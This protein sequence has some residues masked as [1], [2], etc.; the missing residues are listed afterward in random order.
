MA[1]LPDIETLCMNCMSVKSGA[2]LPCPHCGFPAGECAALSGELPPRTILFGRYLLGRMTGR[3]SAGVLYAAYDLKR[4]RRVTIREYFPKVYAKREQIRPG[5]SRVAPISGEAASPFQSGLEQSEIKARQLMRL[6]ALS[7]LF[8][9]QK[10]FS[11]NGTAYAVLDYVQGVTLRKRMESGAAAAPD[12]AEL[13]RPIVSSLARLHGAGLSHGEVSLGQVLF[14]PEGTLM[15]LPPWGAFERKGGPEYPGNARAAARDARAICAALYALLAGKEPPPPSGC[16]KAKDI[17]SL[18]GLGVSVSRQRERA[19]YKG[20][21]GGYRDA[22]ELHWALYGAAPAE[23]GAV[24]GRDN[25]AT[26]SLEKAVR[27]ISNTGGGKKTRPSPPARNGSPFPAAY[28]AFAVLQLTVGIFSAARGGG[29]APYA[30]FACALMNGLSLIKGFGASPLIRALH[31]AAAAYA[32]VF[33]GYSL[34]APGPAGWPPVV[35][36]ALP[37]LNAACILLE[38]IRIRGARKKPKQ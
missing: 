2:A 11:E 13:I 7:G 1:G 27:T 30:L 29:A 22:R 24:R 16:E 38:S 34:F 35:S 25:N 14:T 19:I 6:G 20:L 18:T 15:L 28:A 12:A 33:A 4:C 23:A 21:C 36:A 26:V 10:C 5:V 17:P 32:A 9:P 37:L 31:L 3:W 8:I